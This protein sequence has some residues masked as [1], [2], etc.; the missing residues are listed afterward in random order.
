M[1][2]RETKQIDICQLSRAVHPLRYEYSPILQREVVW[3]EFVVRLFNKQFQAINQI[4]RCEAQSVAVRRIRHNPHNPVFGQRTACPSG[5]FVCSPPLVS[6]LMECVICIQQCYEDVNV[7]QRAHC[8]D[9]FAVY[10]L[11]NSFEC[12]E[13]ATRR[14]N[15]NT[16][17]HY[18]RIASS[19]FKSL[20]SK[21]GDHLAYSRAF[22][23]S[24][25]SGG[26]QDIIFNVESGSHAS[27]ANASQVLC[28]AVMT[29]NSFGKGAD[30]FAQVCAWAV[31][32]LTAS[33]GRKL[34]GSNRKP[35]S[36]V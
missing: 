6:T 29:W 20:A 35:R 19:A 8:S 31:V 4:R 21:L 22:A 12:D 15:G 2:Y 27:D 5:L 9:G 16:I 7:E 17:S 25:F 28:Q 24:Q 3:P 33:I 1:G 13:F 14:Q 26:L 11:L 34:P 23:L 10:Y 32:V 18:C 30:R 36:S